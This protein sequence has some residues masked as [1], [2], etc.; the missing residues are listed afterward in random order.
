MNTRFP[1]AIGVLACGLLT[2]GPALASQAS[3]LRGDSAVIANE[4]TIGDKWMLA[5]NAPL[6]MAGYPA[7][8]AT[9]GDDACLAIGYRINE[10]GSTSDFAILKQWNSA[11]GD[12]EP[13]DGYW[14]AFAEAGA[15]AVSQWKFKPRPEVKVAHETYTVATIAFTGAR[16]T[17]GDTRSHC[18][19]RDLAGLI[20]ERKARYVMDYS[21]ERRDLDR[22][23]RVLRAEE[24]RRNA[25][26][27]SWLQQ[28]RPPPPPPP[29]NPGS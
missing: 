8:F 27:A 19:I 23:A 20:Q 11:K 24:I 28:H 12:E 21:R 9:R 15:D 1:I 17:G 4:G 2:Q 18:Q 13:V 16:T 7:E 14:Q 22:A 5:D 10:D 25:A 29:P 26:R 3:L 6:P